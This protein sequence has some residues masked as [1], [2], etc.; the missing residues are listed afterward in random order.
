MRRKLLSQ[1]ANATI[2]R[3]D[4]AISCGNLGYVLPDEKYD[5]AVTLLQEAIRLGE[6][7]SAE[8]PQMPRYRHKLGQAYRS[9]GDR[10]SSKEIA[11]AEKYLNKANETF[12]R[13]TKD[14]PRNPKYRRFLV[15]TLDR[16][17][18]V[19]F[20]LGRLPIAERYYREAVANLKK[21]TADFS[22][23]A[24]F[25]RERA[26]GQIALGRFLGLAGKLK[27]SLETLHQAQKN[28]VKLDQDAPNNANIEQDLLRTHDRLARALAFW[29]PAEQ[30]DLKR[31]LEHA[32][33]ATA[34][35]ENEIAY[36]LTLSMVHY[37]LGN[38]E[39]ALRGLRTDDI[40]H[41]F[42]LAMTK[43][44]LKD[45]KEARRMFKLG[46]SLL[47]KERLPNFELKVLQR[48]AKRVL[49]Q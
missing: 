2:Y 27:E 49:G 15:Y 37:R 36:Q 5:E 20:N 25:Q 4:V 1:H 29:A 23:V 39:A 30:R 24:E 33:K 14:L 11:K 31:A 45:D 41:C 16:L 47:N 9:L 28:L 3:Y 12:S 8:S 19:N 10:L 17:A 48:E 13:L 21:L 34:G 43:K 22:G 18:Y 40:E 42:L 7:L 38:F 26:A 35:D 46:M 44:K 6:L 32:R